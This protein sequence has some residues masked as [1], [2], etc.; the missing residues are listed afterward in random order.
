MKGDD[1][2]MKGTPEPVG[3]GGGGGGSPRTFLPICCV[4]VMYGSNQN[5][6]VAF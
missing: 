4:E 6:Q 1:D 3:V 2:N 5:T